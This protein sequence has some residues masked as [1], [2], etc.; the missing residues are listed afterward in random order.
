MYA[1]ILLGLDYDVIKVA[2]SK[3]EAPSVDTCGKFS[4]GPGL[5]VVEV[6]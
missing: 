6:V 3:L 2:C 5:V 1:I 4:S